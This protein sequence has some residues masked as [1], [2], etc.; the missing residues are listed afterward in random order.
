MTDK[1][2]PSHNFELV[3]ATAAELAPVG[4][5]LSSETCRAI[6]ASAINLLDAVRA[7]IDERKNN[8]SENLTSIARSLNFPEFLNWS[9]G[10]MFILGTDGGGAD[11]KFNDFL[12]AKIRN[13]KRNKLSDHNHRSQKTR[14]KIKDVPSTTPAELNS[15]LNRYKKEGFDRSALQSLCDYY[16]VWRRDIDGRRKK[17]RKT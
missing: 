8:R 11:A 2:L 7:A 14:L 12:K 5:S 1:K 13:D 4:K 16:R 3:A 9:Q 10:K 17:Q 15:L 6:A